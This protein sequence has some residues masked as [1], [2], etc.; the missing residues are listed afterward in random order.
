MCIALFEQFIESI[1]AR[2]ASHTVHAAEDS[3]TVGVRSGIHWLFPHQDPHC[4]QRTT[5]YC[6]FM[7]MCSGQALSES[8]DTAV[9]ELVKI[10]LEDCKRREEA[11]EE[12]RQ[13]DVR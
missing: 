1:S 6:F 8:G 11:M 12:R 7:T 4:T 9:T 5:V 13:R 10:L 3:P 2:I